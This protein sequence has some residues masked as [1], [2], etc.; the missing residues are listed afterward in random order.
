MPQRE[1]DWQSLAVAYGPI[2]PIVLFLLKVHWDTVYRVIP[3]AIRRLR[4]EM[5]RS[6]KANE[7]IARALCKLDSLQALANQAKTKARARRRQRTGSGSR[8]KGP[9]S[10]EGTGRK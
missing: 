5:R 8:K 9:R 1:I 6:G 3:D 2:V 7:R 4:G 10:F